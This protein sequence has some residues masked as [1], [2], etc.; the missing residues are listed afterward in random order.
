MTGK[1][2]VLDL[3]ETLVHSS[4]QQTLDSDFQFKVNI[5]DAG[6]RT[7]YVKVGWSSLSDIEQDK[8]NIGMD[9]DSDYLNS[10]MLDG[11]DVFVHI[12]N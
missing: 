8:E 9:I 2:L 6:P 4:L 7:V 11:R 10:D 1:T 5:P 12:F 3:D